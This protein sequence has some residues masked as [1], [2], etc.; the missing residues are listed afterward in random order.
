MDVEEIT[1]LWHL[2]YRGSLGGRSTS[3]TRELEPRPHLVKDMPSLCAAL[4]ELRQGNG[5][6]SFRMM[7][8]RARATGKELSRSTAFRISTRQQAPTSAECLEAYLVACEV[9]PRGRA[10]WLEAWLQAQRH[11]VSVRQDA[12]GREEMKQLESVVAENIRGQVS[13]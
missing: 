1:R 7:E 12:D 3:R 8:S 4:E 6:P 11:A 10:V 9:P 13:Q 2:A 5:A